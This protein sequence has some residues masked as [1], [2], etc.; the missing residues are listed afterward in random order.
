M[1]IVLLIII[2]SYIE[3]NYATNIHNK[4]IKLM[5]VATNTGLPCYI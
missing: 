1:V 2:I 3:T 4:N 5:S